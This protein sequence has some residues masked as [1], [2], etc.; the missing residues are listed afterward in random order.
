MNASLHI[1]ERYTHSTYLE[2]KEKQMFRMNFEGNSL[3]T[4][5]TYGIELTETIVKKLASCQLLL[6]S[7]AEDIIFGG[8]SC[9]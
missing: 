4:E 3:L 2:I 8:V 1:L 9:A 6:G 7:I 5:V